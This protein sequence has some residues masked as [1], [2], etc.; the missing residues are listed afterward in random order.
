M[1]SNWIICTLDM[2]MHD[3]YLESVASLTVNMTFR[4]VQVV[5]PP[6]ISLRRAG[7]LRF[8]ASTG[9]ENAL[10]FRHVTDSEGSAVYIS[11]LS[12]KA[13]REMCIAY[14]SHWGLFPLQVALF[15]TD[16][17]TSC[18]CGWH[19]WKRTTDHADIHMTLVAAAA[20]HPNHWQFHT[21]PAWVS[22]AWSELASKPTGVAG[23]IG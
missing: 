15:L 4:N 5:L 18:L 20:W 19:G 16:N 8:V 10:A 11:H 6:S 22:A 17:C 12:R 23:A 3:T 1:R 7:H 14:F 2:E 9:T 21:R 13:P